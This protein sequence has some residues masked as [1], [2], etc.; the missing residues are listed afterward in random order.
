[1]L[2]EVSPLAEVRPCTVSIGAAGLA[3]TPTVAPPGPTLFTLHNATA[4]EQVLLLEQAA[5]SDQASTAAAVTSLQAFR[6]LFSSEALRPGETIS[7]SSL[8]DSVHRPERL[9]L[10]LP[11]HR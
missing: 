7:V 9:H 11:H 10:A 5:W 4:R 8:S 2:L 3:V 1:M 6:N